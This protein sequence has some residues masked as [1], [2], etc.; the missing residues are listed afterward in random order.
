MKAIRFAVLLALGLTFLMGLNLNTSVASAQ[1]EK[2]FVTAVHEDLKGGN[3]WI[4]TNNGA[5][6]TIWNA[7]VWGWQHIALY[8]LTVPG[9][10]P[11]PS[12]AAD[13][14]GPFT[15]EGGFSVATVNLLQG[16]KWSDGTEITAND[17]AFTFN[18]FVK[19]NPA[20]GNA[21]SID[22]GGGFPSWF[23]AEFVD[24]VEAQGNYTVKF[25]FKQKPGLARWEFG[26]LLSP[27]LQKAYWEPKFNQAFASANPVQTLSAFDGTDEPSA[28]GF[29]FESWTPGAFAEISANPN[30]F[31]KGTLNREYGETGSDGHWER[32]PT[33]VERS[34]G[35]LS[36]QLIEYTTGPFVDG[37]LF[38]LFGS[39]AAAALAVISGDAD[40]HFNPLG[41][42]LA[43]LQQLQAANNVR[44]LS[45]ADNGVFYLSF[46]MRKVPFNYLEFRQAVRC[47]VDKEFVASSLLQNLVVVAD[48][49]VPPGNGFWY[50]PLTEEEQQ[51]SCKGMS[52]ADRLAR[53]KQLL[54]GAGFQFN[55]Q[56]I[57]TAD[58][59]GN[60]IPQLELL[61]PN[62]AYDNNRNIFGLHIVDRLQKLGVLVRD[63]PAGFNNIVTLV[64]DL[65]DFDMWQLGWSLSFYPDYLEAFFGSRNAARQGN[66][67][68][69]G[70]CSA[71][72]NAINGC[73]DTFDDL[74]FQFLAESDVNKA[75]DL[76]FQLQ[77]M[78][79]DYVAYVPTHH[80]VV[81]DAFRVDR[82]GWQGLEDKPLLGG[83]S[84]SLSLGQLNLVAGK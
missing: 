68:Q 49:V 21:L 57:L 53:A 54:V 36:N 71:R 45:N 37:V 9:F 73:Q 34:A 35:D 59:E 78:V 74:S 83:F 44:V 42:G 60:P 31:F 29:Q 46:N 33:G 63:V 50:R 84:N 55:A 72:E 81:N 58:P 56:G 77:K 52:E 10:S 76:A 47:V 51:E 4:A 16:V 27:I 14:A 30:F 1:A 48:N 20:T 17:V 32:L 11:F 22:L 13:F 19:V 64:F 15:E 39:Q 24:H 61:H 69:G 2:I 79:F 23:D 7:Y 62:A 75:R 82:I 67:A 3:S 40:Y 26:A 6:N 18:N 8:G 80:V 70:V 5:N 43:T 41:Y 66:A 65:Q 38:N 25:F 12:L 28:W